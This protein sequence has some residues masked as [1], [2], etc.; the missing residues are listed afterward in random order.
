MKS[1]VCEAKS[2]S[3]TIAYS[4]RESAHPEIYLSNTQAKSK[5]KITNFAG[6]NAHKLP[7]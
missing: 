6:G 2:E 1:I 7:G 4:A 5:I 3:Y